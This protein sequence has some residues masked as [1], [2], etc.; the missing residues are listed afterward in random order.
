MLNGADV[1]QFARFALNGFMATAVHF[2][3]LTILV[4][5]LHFQSKGIA[6][7]FAAVVGIAASYLGNRIFVFHAS[8]GKLGRQLPRFIALYAV[9][10]LLSGLLMGIWSDMLEYDYRLGF[11]LVSGVQLVAS[12]T[13]NR[14]LVFKE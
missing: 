3:S 7:G 2:G 10:A 12:F 8:A 6:N 11:L 4:E 1:R 5:L 9:L 13:G 14:L